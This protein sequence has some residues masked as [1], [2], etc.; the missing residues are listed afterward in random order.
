MM[1]YSTIMFYTGMGFA[2][3]REFK[4]GKGKFTEEKRKNEPWKDK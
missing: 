1:E 4:S 3:F 2:Q